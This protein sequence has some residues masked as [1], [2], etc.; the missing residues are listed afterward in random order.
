MW[1]EEDYPSEEEIKG[2]FENVKYKPFGKSY[3]DMVLLEKVKVYL[4]LDEPIKMTNFY[5]APEIK[6]SVL[7]EKAMKYF[8]D[9]LQ[10]KEYTLAEITEKYN[11]IM[12]PTKRINTRSFSKLKFIS[13]YFNRKKVNKKGT[14]MR[15]YTKK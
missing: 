12:H 7:E 1:E 15:I 13:K 10:N 3:D 5:K 8:Y 2:D 6:C 14:I 11:D 9:H 4:T